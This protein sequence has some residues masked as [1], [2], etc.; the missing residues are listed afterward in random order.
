MIG[1]LI[2]QAAE[3]LNKKAFSMI[4]DTR[5][6]KLNIDLGEITQCNNIKWGVVKD[7]KQKVLIFGQFQMSI[8]QK[9]FV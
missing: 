1:P 5:P 3:V 2:G 7:G 4:N 9:W 6:V 8:S